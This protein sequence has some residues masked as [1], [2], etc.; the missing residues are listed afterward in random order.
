MRFPLELRFRILAVAAQASLRDATGH[1]LCYVKQKAFTLKEA[2]TVFGDEAQQQPLYR[3]NA[4]RV[5]DISAQYRIDDMA[6]RS[7]GVVRRR[8]MRSFWRALYE[9]HRG[10]QHV[11][12][13]QEENPWV[14]VADG[15]L[16][17]IPL[18]GLLSGYLFHPAYGVTHR[19]TGAVVLR[20][21]K[22]PAFLEGVFRI[23]A[24][25]ALND[26]DERLAVLGVLMVL[27]LERRRG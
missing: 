12:T 24:V 21:V 22:R 5:I 15:L 23:E 7:L 25:N 6:G 2:V 3:I 16:T 4:D 20:V 11:F 1:L 8:G 14:K 27:L 9:I 10:G 18:L 13:V 19:D 17:E 26:D